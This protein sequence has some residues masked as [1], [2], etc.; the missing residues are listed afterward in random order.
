MFITIIISVDISR[1]LNQL[2]DK[3]CQPSVVMILFV[4]NM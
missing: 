4:I 2:V 1:S 3:T